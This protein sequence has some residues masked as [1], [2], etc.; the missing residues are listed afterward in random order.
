MRLDKLLERL[1]YEVVQGS[2]GIEVTTLVNDSRKVEDGSVFVCISGAVSDGHKFIP[3]V[4]E[5]GASAVVVEREAEVPENVT[6]IRVKDTR[7]ALALMSAAY[8][9]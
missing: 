3:D 7:Y 6:V 1:E 2:D 8:F 4:A 5:K 9:D